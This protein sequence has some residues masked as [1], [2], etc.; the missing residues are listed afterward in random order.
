VSLGSA[1]LMAHVP[2]EATG[3]T[4]PATVLIS[5]ELEHADYRAKLGDPSCQSACLTLTN[6]IADS[7]VETLRST[8]KYVTWSRT[9]PANDTVSISWITDRE[10][11]EELGVDLKFTVMSATS[12]DGP[13]TFSLDFEDYRERDKRNLR[14]AGWTPTAMA[15]EWVT[16]LTQLLL[17]NPNLGQNIFTELPLDASVK[18]G[19][20]PPASI[21]VSYASI[22]RNPDGAAPTFRVRAKVVDTVMQTSS[23]AMISLDAC[24][25]R[26][27]SLGY[28]CGVPKVK[29]PSTDVTNDAPSLVRRATITVKSIHVNELVLPSVDSVAASTPT[30]PPS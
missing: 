28:S 22:G 19:A 4:A 15:I 7:I 24:V 17:R 14:P 2:V 3:S 5:V 1:L 26:T 23:P 12:T 10:R 16:R 30:P 9:G 29:Y 13:R 6:A 25:T 21:T 18:F 11:E 20:T 27:D 8:F